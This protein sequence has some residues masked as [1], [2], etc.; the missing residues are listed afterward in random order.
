[1][2]HQKKTMSYGVYSGGS[3]MEQKREAILKLDYGLIDRSEYE[4]NQIT[5][6]P[7]C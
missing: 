7:R 5:I 4:T 3:S 1:M 2:G 6:H